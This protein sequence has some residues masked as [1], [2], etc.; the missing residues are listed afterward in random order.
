VRTKVIKVR[1][2]FEKPPCY[3]SM[4]E[5]GEEY[6]KDF[7]LTCRSFK[8]CKKVGAGKSLKKVEIPAPVV[9]RGDVRSRW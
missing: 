4:Y 9:K 2:K 7:C 8:E 1:T 6:M 3:G 5:L